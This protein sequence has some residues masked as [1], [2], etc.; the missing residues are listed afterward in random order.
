MG[1]QSSPLIL[2][3]SNMI[4]RLDQI[5]YLETRLI[6]F[7]EL[8][9]WQWTVEVRHLFKYARG[10]V[11]TFCNTMLVRLEFLALRPP[12]VTL[13]LFVNCWAH[14]YVTF[15]F[16]L[17]FKLLIFG[18]KLEYKCF[19]ARE[20]LNQFLITFFKDLDFFAKTFLLNLGLVH[21]FGFFSFCLRLA[22]LVWF[23]HCGQV[24]FDTQNKVFLLSEQFWS[25]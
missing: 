22:F 8:S 4:L 15:R 24:K 1:S 17:I 7:A 23:V 5:V 12:R 14:R 21:N 3:K 9:L 19:M 18:F 11:L 13:L 10:Q 2:C 16:C 20:L 6:K 25:F